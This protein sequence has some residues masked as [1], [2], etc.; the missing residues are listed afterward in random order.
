MDSRFPPSQLH[1]SEDSKQVVSPKHYGF[2]AETISPLNFLKFSKVFLP[3]SIHWASLGAETQRSPI[4]SDRIK[5]DNLTENFV[6]QIQKQNKNFSQRWLFEIK[7]KNFFSF[8]P[9]QSLFHFTQAFENLVSLHTQQICHPTDGFSLDTDA[10]WQKF[11]PLL[12][13]THFRAP[14]S[15]RSL[16]W[17]LKYD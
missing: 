2:H 4:C 13:V 9:P 5:E 8:F 16:L 15:D 14:L 7:F 10:A 1:K 6:W 11:T 3:S 17:Q 12:Q